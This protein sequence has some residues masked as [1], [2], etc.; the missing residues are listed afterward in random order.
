MKVI[1][2]EGGGGAIDTVGICSFRQRSQV[3]TN[4]T[5]RLNF[6]DS[7]IANEKKGNQNRESNRLR[8]KTLAKEYFPIDEHLII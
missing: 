2:L 6:H 8:K 4:S 3:E 1:E 7:A 5:G